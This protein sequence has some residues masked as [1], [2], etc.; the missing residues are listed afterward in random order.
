MRFWTGQDM[1]KKINKKFMSLLVKKETGHMT[2][3]GKCDWYRYCGIYSID[4]DCAE[5]QVGIK[6]GALTMTFTE[7]PDFN[8]AL[9]AISEHQFCFAADPAKNT[10]LRF[11][12][13]EKGNIVSL[14]F[15]SYTFKKQIT[16]VNQ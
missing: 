16:T 15:L 7:K 5:A 8:E 13:N 10:M 11:I 4:G 12:A 2:S 6:D 9:M 14:E 3:P 1:L